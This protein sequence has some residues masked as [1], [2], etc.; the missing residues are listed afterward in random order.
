MKKITFGSLFALA[1]CF[2]F[3]CDNKGGGSDNYS[4]STEEIGSGEGDEIA[5]TD[6][7]AA[8]AA[9]SAEMTTGAPATFV[10]VSDSNFVAKATSG[11][12]LEV[13]LGQAATTKGSSAEVKKFGKKMVE[14]HSKANAELKEIA[15]KKGWPAEQRMAVEEKTDYN[16]IS[17]LSG[18]DF[19]REY[20]SKMV[21]DHEKTIAMFEQ[22]TQ[23][24][25]DPDLKAFASKTLP[26]LRM[27]LD[28]ARE[29]NNKLQGM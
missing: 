12:I 19:D 4:T 24:A 2:G 17:G 7:D 14:D 21:S 8:Q 9:D 29:N 1:V 13:Q 22:A 26:N 18:N 25:T 11:G 6:N 3:G 23:K 5:G 16:R 15:R 10:Y 27:H 20:M 28:M